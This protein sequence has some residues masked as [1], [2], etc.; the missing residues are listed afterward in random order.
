MKDCNELNIE[1]CPGCRYFG[2]NSCWIIS[3]YNW[4]RK[5]QNKQELINHINW[6]L[7]D[8]IGDWIFY[9]SKT[10]ELYYPQYLH[11]IDKCLILK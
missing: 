8:N 7:E 11:I 4:I 2:K 9:F 10:I 6:L 5:L 3:D 1:I